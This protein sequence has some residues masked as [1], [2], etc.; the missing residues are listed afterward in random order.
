MF[1]DTQGDIVRHR[2]GLLVEEDDPPEVICKPL[3]SFQFQLFV[4]KDL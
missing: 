2:A 1:N 3:D 4:T